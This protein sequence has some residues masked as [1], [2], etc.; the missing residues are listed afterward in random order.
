MPYKPYPIYD[1]QTGKVT[2]REP[3]LLL[4]DAFE[5]LR[6]CYLFR[7]V[8]EKRRGFSI[9]GKYGGED[10]IL[11][12]GD[13]STKAY[14]GNGN[15]AAT[16]YHNSGAPKAQDD[17]A[18]DDTGDWADD[19]A[20]ISLAFDTTHYEIT[21]DAAN[22]KCWLA[23]LAFTQNNYYRITV[24]ITNG[25]ASAVDFDLYFDDGAAQ[26]S[27]K[28]ST[29][30]TATVHTV[31]VKAAS[32][33]ATGK[34]GIRII[35]DM[36][37]DNVEI[38]DFSCY[39]VELIGAVTEGTFVVTDGTETFTDNEDGT[40]TGD[41]GGS[42]TIT[43]ATG[44]YEVTFNANVSDAQDVT[45]TYDCAPETITIM[46]LFN[47]YQDDV[48]K[49]IAANTE[50]LYNLNA[51]SNKYEELQ[52]KLGN[53]VTDFS[54]ADSAF[55]WWENWFNIGYVTNGVDQIQQY[56]GTD[57]EDFNIDLDVEAGPDN[58]VNT[59]QLMFVFQSRLCIFNTT[60]RGT[61]RT[62]RARWCEVD[63]VGTWKDANYLDV[64]TNDSIVSGGY[65][66]SQLFI[67]CRRSTWEFLYTGD[68]DAPFRWRRVSRAEG[69]YAKCGTIN[70]RNELLF[71][72][73]ARLL[74]TDGRQV[75]E[76]DPQIPNFVLDWNQDVIDYSYAA[77]LQ[78]LQQILVS[79]AESDQSKPNSAIVLNYEG[80]SYGTYGLDIHV[81]GEIR[82]QTDLVL[83]R[84]PVGL[85]LDDIDYSF[86]DPQAQGGYP[87][88]LMGCRDGY[89]Y[90]LNDGNTDGT[91]DISFEAKGGRWNPYIE[92]RKKARLGKI[93][94]LVD[95]DSGASFDVDSYINTED[96]S[97]QTVSVSCADPNSADADYVTR[98]KIRVTVDV[99]VV[100]NLHRIKLSNSASNNRPRIHE[101]VPWFQEAGRLD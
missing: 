61:A 19:G 40:L 24:S 96:T 13:G 69:A 50:R 18:D 43:Y 70:Y 59:C 46:G 82:L 58:D 5:T 47:Y 56:D 74:G 91:S 15:F 79:Y 29:T 97:F 78:E 92:K 31:V 10:E 87:I 76:V 77:K 68:P 84:L 95:V 9:F 2:A 60:E 81:L 1:F 14:T 66:G 62:V 48:T 36:S 16:A 93:E 100:A 20:N 99:N 98:D 67:K 54:G 32:T 7:G 26:Y 4:K 22:Q 64:P 85:A 35:T 42:G 89:I 83:D 86:D 101:I 53:S 6:D 63:T 90:R 30:A 51:T 44:E 57:L 49:V 21:T 17:C 3:W 12:T 52:F 73:Q 33:T 27:Y 88:T 28:R 72:G 38:T 37:A 94:F 41:A 55:F 8:L 65:I 45:I 75:Y 71:V 34:A 39:E 23:N 11:A 80:K 25:T